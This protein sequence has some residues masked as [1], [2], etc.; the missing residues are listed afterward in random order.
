MEIN[1]T[2]ETKDQYPNEQAFDYRIITVV[3]VLIMVCAMIITYFWNGKL[4]GSVENLNLKCKMKTNK[5][6]EKTEP[7]QV[8]E[9]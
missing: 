2:T 9:Q 3:L 6:A 5:T 7:T 4:K 1:T 8:H